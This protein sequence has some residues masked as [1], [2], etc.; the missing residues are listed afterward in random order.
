MA[1]GAAQ[2]EGRIS[3][4]IEEQ[5]GLLAAFH[6]RLDGPAQGRGQPAVAGRCF[7]AHVEEGHLG[8]GGTAVARRQHGQSVAAGLDVGHRL[9]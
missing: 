5:H 6:R 9:Q 7:P 1:A 3:P 8:H 4:A 2:R